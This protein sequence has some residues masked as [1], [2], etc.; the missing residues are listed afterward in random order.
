MSS[1][2]TLDALEAIPIDRIVRVDGVDW[3][4]TAKGLSRDG[5][6]LGLFHF[7]GRVLAGTVVDVDSM[8][9]AEGEWWAGTTRVYYIYRV[10]DR[11]VHY[12]S[13]RNGAVYNWTGS[14]RKA[15]WDSSATLHRLSEAPP[16][17]ANS[18]FAGAVVQMGALH[19]ETRAQA[20]TIQRLT[21]ENAQLQ[22]QARTQARKPGQVREYVANIR[23]NLDAIAD[24]LEE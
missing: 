24:L 7:E 14:S 10:T 4:R 16:E 15:T 9:V 1:I 23:R 20:E 18:G 13:F 22:A 17:L 12:S 6:D 5:V 3:T 21:Q 8:P 19:T 11:M 2:I